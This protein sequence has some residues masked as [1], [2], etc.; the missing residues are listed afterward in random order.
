[1]GEEKKGER[2]KVNSEYAT[3]SRKGFFIN[4]AGS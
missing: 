3:K 2:A 1:M 4:F